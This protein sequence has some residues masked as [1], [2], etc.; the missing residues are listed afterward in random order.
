MTL[1]IFVVDMFSMKSWF[2]ENRLI[3]SLR[4]EW[5][6]GHAKARPQEKIDRRE[7]WSI[8]DHL[9]LAILMGNNST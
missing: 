1:F 2:H 9:A 8:N 6:N 5:E 3:D 4:D 7:I